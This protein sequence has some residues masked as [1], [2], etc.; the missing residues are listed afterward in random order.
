MKSMKHYILTSFCNQSLHVPSA[1]FYVGRLHLLN[2]TILKSQNQYN[3][4]T[5]M[6]TASNTITG[7]V[8]TVNTTQRLQLHNLILLF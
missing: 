8:S 2:I 4:C 6:V 3:L 7:K 1:H 5:L